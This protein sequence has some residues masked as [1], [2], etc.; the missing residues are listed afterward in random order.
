MILTKEDFMHYNSDNS[1]DSIY[2]GDVYMELKKNESYL[3]YIHIEE[4]VAEIKIIGAYNMGC[5][6]GSLYSVYFKIKRW[7]KGIRMVDYKKNN[8]GEI[9]RVHFNLC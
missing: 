7:G 4:N 9:R 8:I 2:P 5:T 3:P 6:G 1:L